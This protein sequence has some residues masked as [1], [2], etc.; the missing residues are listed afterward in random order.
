M[1]RIRHW[2]SWAEPVARLRK[3]WKD[4]RKLPH[5]FQHAEVMDQML[6]E[7]VSGGKD[8]PCVI[9]NWDNTPVRVAEG[10]LAGSTPELFRGTCGGHWTG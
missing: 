4:K 2:I 3:Y 10:G 6:A 5:I 1:P 8:Y 9:P 7:N